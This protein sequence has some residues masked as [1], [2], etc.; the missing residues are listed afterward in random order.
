ME[1]CRG[2]GDSEGE[3][4]PYVCELHDGY[5]THEWIGRQPWCDGNVGTFGLSY[6]GFTQTLPASLRSKYL[7][8]VA[9]IASEKQPVRQSPG[10][11]HNRESELVFGGGVR[12][13][14]GLG[15]PV[16]RGRCRRR[17]RA[18]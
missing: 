18:G 3:W 14:A 16:Q 12:G 1:D 9:P 2:R 5:D 10:R 6:P 17:R 11:V 4:E 15:V 8:A 13:V 7:K